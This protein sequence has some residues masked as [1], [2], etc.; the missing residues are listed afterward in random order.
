MDFEH[1]VVPANGE[2]I[3]VSADGALD[4]P[5][6][7]VIPFIVGDG[8]GADVTPAMQHVVDAAVAQAY[9][10]QKRIVWM[11]VYAGRAAPPLYGDNEYLPAETLAALR[12]FVVSIK[13]P[14]ATPVGGG[15]TSLNVKIRQV[16]D[17]YACV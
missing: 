6:N 16:M 14:L 5:N 3:A 8:I 17:L 10:G 15:F 1:I 2:R 11:Q 12:E 4:V 9:G 13:G 7:P